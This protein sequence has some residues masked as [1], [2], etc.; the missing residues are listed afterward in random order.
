MVPVEG[1]GNCWY[2]AISQLMYG[3][4]NDYQRIRPELGAYV[5]VNTDHLDDFYVPMQAHLAWGHKNEPT[6]T[7][8][9]AC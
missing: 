1:D 5:S 8:A 2:K 6:A 9:R 4:F 7:D 3:I